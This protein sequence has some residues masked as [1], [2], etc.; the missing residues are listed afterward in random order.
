MSDRTADLLLLAQDRGLSMKDLAAVLGIRPDN[1]WKATQRGFLQVTLVA[2]VA[3]ALEL[4]LDH[5]LLVAAREE[6]Y[7]RLPRGHSYKERFR[8][9]LDGGG[10][11]LAPEWSGAV[12][13]VREG[14]RVD[15]AAAV[16]LGEALS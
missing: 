11:L 9:V 3:I 15:R 5:W 1:F 2:Q 7:R 10:R 16:G 6:V 4:D 8:P 14:R 13:S 12:T